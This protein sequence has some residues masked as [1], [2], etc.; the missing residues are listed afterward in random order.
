MWLMHKERVLQSQAGTAP[1]LEEVK[2]SLQFW[3]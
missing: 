2:V 1:T 3:E